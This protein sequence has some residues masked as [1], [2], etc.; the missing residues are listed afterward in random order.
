M[1]VVIYFLQEKKQEKFRN[2]FRSSPTTPSTPPSTPSTSTSS[3]PFSLQVST[4][5]FLNFNGSTFKKSSTATSFTL[6][7]ENYLLY[8]SKCITG[9][10]NSTTFT[11]KD[12]Q[13]D[14]CAGSLKYFGTSITTGISNSINFGDKFLTLPNYE[15]T[16]KLVM[17]GTPTPFTKI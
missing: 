7:P 10:L 16:F 1:L 17:S 15:S 3:A 6:S 4:G 8:N 11:T 13:K 12:Y 2:T 14:T 5:M 9:T